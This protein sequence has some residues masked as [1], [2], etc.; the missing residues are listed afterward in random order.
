MIKLNIQ[1]SSDSKSKI[2][3][4]S[5]SKT[6][7][8]LFDK[9]HIED[10]E[11]RSVP[12]EH[13]SPDQNQ[14]RKIFNQEAL[15]ELAESIKEHGVLQPIILRPGENNTFIIIS[16]ERRFR[17]SK[18]VGLTEISSIIRTN[19]KPAEI[20]IIENLQRQDLQPF[21]EAEA[22][23][24][25][26]KEYGYTQQQLAKVI[27]KKQNTISQILSLNKLPESIK[28][29][30]P[31]A[32]ISKRTLIEIARQS[33][34]EEM[35]KLYSQTVN[36]KLSSDD[37]RKIKKSGTSKTLES[38][39]AK[40]TKTINNLIK[41]LL[42]LKKLNISDDEKNKVKKELKKLKDCIVDLNF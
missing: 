14:P 12:I 23:E 38:P 24:R 33:S 42:K 13:I 18:L 37:V 35:E 19:V 30:Y 26:I 20:A 5:P 31:R 7:N 22:F 10:G 15:E 11:F 3:T 29:E 4:S 9:S 16:G 39:T 17:A 1:N 28:Q 2:T 8:I 32:D 36:M 27:G 21:E 25:M 6:K 40:T 41:G 34:P